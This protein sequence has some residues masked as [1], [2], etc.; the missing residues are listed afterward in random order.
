MHVESATELTI[1]MPCLD[2]A[3]TIAS[4]IRNAQAFL[5]GSGVRGEILVVAVAAAVE[6]AAFAHVM[7]HEHAAGHRAFVIADRRGAA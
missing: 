6:L 2:E 7:K 4:C 1:L 5:A 3:E